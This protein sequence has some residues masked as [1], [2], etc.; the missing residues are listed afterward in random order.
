MNS[1]SP[2][3]TSQ[4][5]RPMTKVSNSANI[6]AKSIASSMMIQS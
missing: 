5:L 6:A 2:A 1:M 3:D 4:V